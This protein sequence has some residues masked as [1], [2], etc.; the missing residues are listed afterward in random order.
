MRV[1]STCISEVNTSQ[2]AVGLIKAMGVAVPSVRIDVPPG[3]IEQNN[4]LGRLVG[5]GFFAEVREMWGRE[6]KAE[7]TRQVCAGSG[8]HCTRGFV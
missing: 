3:A 5:A 6:C 7:E 4:D 2:E 8:E 1:R